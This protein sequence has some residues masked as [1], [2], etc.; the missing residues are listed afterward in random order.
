MKKKDKKGNCK[1]NMI[2][3]FCLKSTLGG[4]KYK[5][6]QQENPFC[7]IEDKVKLMNHKN[8]IWKTQNR[9]QIPNV[10]SFN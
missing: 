3:Y 4:S 6:G 9:S 10:V 5:T 2:D 1:E 8:K 7:E